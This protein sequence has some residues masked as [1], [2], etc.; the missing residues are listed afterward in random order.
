MFEMSS[1]LV[2]RGDQEQNF[3]LAG[4]LSQHATQDNEK[5]DK[6]ESDVNAEIRQVKL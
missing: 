5:S 2:F 1:S 6:N 4:K 3:Q